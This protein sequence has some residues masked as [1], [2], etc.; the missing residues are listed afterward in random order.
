MVPGMSTPTPGDPLNPVDP[1]PTDPP[2]D[3]FAKADPPPRPGDPS[4]DPPTRPTEP[5]TGARPRR[6][7]RSS[8]DRVLGG[9][10][11]GLGRYFD[12]DPVIFRIGFGVSVLFGGVGFLAYLVALAFVP[13]D[14]DG[15][16]LADRSRTLTI[17]G[18]ILIGIASLAVLDDAG[19]FFGPLVWFALLTGI[20]YAIYRTARRTRTGGPSEVTAGRV[21]TWLAIGTGAI[22][23]LSILAIGAGWAAAEGGGAIVA[24]VLIAIGVVL[25]AAAASGRGRHA[26][27]LVLPALAIA[28]PLGVVSA[29]DISLDGG[30]GDRTYRPATVAE[31]PAGGYELGAG[32]MRIDLRDVELPAGETV[33]DLR[34]GLGAAEVL[35]KRDVCVEA[36]AEVGAGAIDVRGRDTAGV[37]VDYLV[38]ATSSKPRLRV[39]AD[40]G[41]G[42]LRVADRPDSDWEFDDD[43]RRFHGF[44]HDGTPDNLRPGVDHEDL[45]GDGDVDVRDEHLLDDDDFLDEE[46]AGDR[47]CGA[48]RTAEV[49]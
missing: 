26:G 47:A 39:R 18:V 33:L 2:T 46:L 37:D 16:A 42:A 12:V 11:G 49:G 19:W 30:Y 48:I 36:D 32:A 38:R 24:G 40:V 7:T 14:D 22:V 1:P 5:L 23:V 4:D 45:D 9:V 44:G 43:E 27:W 20:G 21:L 41:L 31:I 29:A 15:R 25:V 34:L 35:V 8:S 3:P 13:R 17:A 10:A 28:V 6:L